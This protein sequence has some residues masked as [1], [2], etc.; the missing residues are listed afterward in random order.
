MTYFFDATNH[1]HKFNDKP[2]K[3]TT[4]V[5]KEVLPPP[6]AWYGSGQAVKFLGWY[7]RNKSRAN[8]LP[9]EEGLPMLE[10]SFAE[11]KKMTPQQFLTLLDK[12]YKAHNEYKKQR[13]E[14]GTNVHDDIE[15]LV[16]WAIEKN[17]GIIPQKDYDIRHIAEFAKWAEGKKFI[18]SEVHVY[19]E[20]L[21]LG[22]I[23]DLVFE[24]NGDLYLGD[25]KTSKSFYESQFIQMGL[26]DVQQMENGFFNPEGVKVGEPIKAKGYEVVRLNGKTASKRY[27]GVERMREFADNLCQ[28]HE[29]LQKLKEFIK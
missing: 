16:K 27:Y 6:L 22:G 29:T 3:G 14:E 21:W 25:I 10:E 7:D 15:K 20:K 28:L 17:E 4:T 12:A 24:E 8:Y 13:G 19:S 18:Q 5:I 9:D 1:T 11:I 23:V 26:Y 2:L